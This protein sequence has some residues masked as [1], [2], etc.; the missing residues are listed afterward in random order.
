V[1]GKISYCVD[2]A[3]TSAT[4]CA[5]GTACTPTSFIGDYVC[6]L[7]GGDS[8]GNTRCMPRACQ[9]DQDCT[10]GPNGR[11]VLVNR[12]AG[13][14]YNGVLITRLDVACVYSGSPADP[15][16]CAGAWS[17]GDGSYHLCPNADG[18]VP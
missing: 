8:Y 15:G 4:D 1:P 5:E 13:Q 18:G 12:A 11:C 3:C 16:A 17:C 2:T 9:S 10:G 6:G 7:T 14:G